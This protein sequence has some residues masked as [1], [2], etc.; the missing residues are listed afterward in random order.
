MSETTPLSTEIGATSPNTIPAYYNRVANFNF[1]NKYV[2]WLKI[3]KEVSNVKS[4]L[5]SISHSE[6]Y[7]LTTKRADL[8]DK[9]GSVHG[10]NKT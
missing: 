8:G 10:P 2:Y 5:V 9:T 3:A 1:L 6:V 4:N 7:K